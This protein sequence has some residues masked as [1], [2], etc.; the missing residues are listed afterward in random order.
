MD[1]EYTCPSC[2][3]SFRIMLA[4][5]V[6]G[7]TKPKAGDAAFCTY[8]Q[9][10]LQFVTDE[11]LVQAD[12]SDIGDRIRPSD[13]EALEREMNRSWKAQCPE[14]GAPLDN[15]AS[16]TGEDRKPGPGDLSL[17]LH[18]GQLLEFKHT[19]ELVPLS[20]AVFDSL[21]RE[22]QRLLLNAQEE[23]LRLNSGSAWDA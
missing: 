4:N 13:R 16:I 15:H 6:P 1:K 3:K 5:D 2:H 10:L 17:C 22:K 20:D 11:L 18:C 8:C 12:M 14:C 19:D 7:V 21:D 23:I 9:T